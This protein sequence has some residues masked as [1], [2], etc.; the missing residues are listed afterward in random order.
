MVVAAPSRLTAL[1]L[2]VAAGCSC[3]G[4]S[5][6]PSV[7]A[8]ITVR[9][10]EQL[11]WNEE[12]PSPQG[13]ALYQFVAYVDDSPRILPDASCQVSADPVRFDCSARLPSMTPGAHRLQ[14]AT[15][16][17]VDGVRFES[18]RSSVL[19]VLVAP[20]PNGN[21]SSAA[22]RV[23][24]AAADGTTFMAE[25]LAR[26][27][28]AP[29][30]LALTPDGRVLIAE[31]AGTVRLWREGRLQTA[32]ALSLA[33]AA[34]GP[35]CGL[36]AIAVHPDFADNR[37][38]YV[39]YTSRAADDA[40]IN[41]V[42]RFRELNDALGQGAI[43]LEDRAPSLPRRAPRIRF[44]PDG[45]LYIAF[46]G[47]AV[48]A[49]DSASYTGKILRLNDDGTTPRDN[50]GYSPILSDEAGVPL[51]FGWQPATGT[52]WQIDRDWSNREL[53]IAPR[54]ATDRRVLATSITPVIDPSGVAFYHSRTIAE[55]TGN[56]FISALEGRQ[57]VR[58][59]FD[60]SNPTQVAATEPLLKDV[61]GR[62]GDI[63]GGADG[64]LYFSTSNR[65]ANGGSTV[66]DD[67]L[68]RIVPAL[69]TKDVSP[70]GK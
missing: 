32:P 54:T 35:D 45:K 43:L 5:S 27:L 61:F 28:D 33:D 65:S 51:A 26:G 56:L 25:T 50:P 48:A 42:V 7:S 62:I 20:P 9:G 6:V 52:R 18:P 11:A 44:G 23:R 66:D 21:A 1:L 57:I 53:L 60:S 70:K 8:P 15:A 3:G 67:R 38:V 36:I 37:E 59:R 34:N 47:D 10:S 64:G 19:N 40:F 12:V 4:S 68:I 58:V 22:A 31:R 41:R 69:L 39:A 30:G 13:L 24:F 55:F 2:V 49:Q 14:L 63:V 16:I 46:P 17:L 29:S